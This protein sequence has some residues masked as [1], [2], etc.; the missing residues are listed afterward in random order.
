MMF[1]PGTVYTIHIR[2]VG[3]ST[4]EQSREPH[5]HLKPGRVAGHLAG[6]LRIESQRPE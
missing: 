3:G 5:C 6:C 1:P 2:A 4:K